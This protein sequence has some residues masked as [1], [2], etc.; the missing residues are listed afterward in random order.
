MLELDGSFQAVGRESADVAGGV[1]EGADD[2]GEALAPLP[3]GRLKGEHAALLQGGEL[4]ADADRVSAPEQVQPADFEGHAGAETGVAGRRVQRIPVAPEARQ[5]GP[6][7]ES[8]GPAAGFLHLKQHVAVGFHPVRVL[9]GHIDL[10]E[11][12]QVVE[13]AL[14]FDHGALGERIVRVNDYLPA[15]HRLA[16]HFVPIHNHLVDE[17]PAALLNEVLELDGMGLGSGLGGPLQGDV[18]E[19]GCEVLAQD[20]VAVAGHAPLTE[21]LAL[22]R[23]EAVPKALGGQRVIA[24]HLKAGDQGLRSFGDLDEH[25]NVALFSLVVV[26]EAVFDLGLQEAIGMVE[27]LDGADVVPQQA[28][29]ET[30]AAEL[31]ALGLEVEALANGGLVEELVAG[32]I[33]AEEVVSLTQEGLELH[34]D[35]AVLLVVLLVVDL[36]VEVALYLE[37][38]A[39]VAGALG[40]QVTVDGALLVDGHVAAELGARKFGAGDGDLDT[41]SRLDLQGQVHAVGGGDPGLFH[42]SDAGLQA[43]ELL[44]VPPEPLQ[45]ALDSGLGERPLG[46]PAG[47]AARLCHREVGFA[48]DA[49]L[50]KAGPRARPDL[51][52]NVNLLGIGV[53][54]LLYVDLGVMVAVVGQQLEQRGAAGIYLVLR[55]GLAQIQ[56][57]HGGHF[58]DAGGRPNAEDP[59]RSDEPVVGGEKGHF[60]AAL[61]RRRV[62]LDVGVAAGREHGLNAA[63]NLVRVEGLA[64]TEGNQ[65]GQTRRRDGLSGRRESDLD[66]QP[67]ELGEG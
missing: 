29:A 15:D 65:L 39:E 12:A 24:G 50:S 51:K 21:G 54:A 45:S 57:K 37:V 25:R 53:R 30:A 8:E 41:G 18:G 34:Q 49:H 56:L 32:D 40:Q 13:P 47:N 11:D 20:Q 59:D 33:Q 38:V 4:G 43:V 58:R 10:G 6:A 27:V 26:L 36:G 9:Q 55:E 16:S 35:D 42:H 52:R 7:A 64:G 44:V 2:E 28:V 19:S 23:A 67:A 1:V 31:H 46:R 22:D 14:A 61:G 62:H 63:P 60:D 17:L 66:H 5:F 48:A 3:A